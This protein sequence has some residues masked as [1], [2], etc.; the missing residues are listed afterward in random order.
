MR[1]RAFEGNLAILNGSTRLNLADVD[2]NASWDL[3]GT[4]PKGA[5][6]V[7]TRTPAPGSVE[8]LDFAEMAKDPVVGSLVGDFDNATDVRH[9]AAESLGRLADPATLET[10]RKLAEEYPEHSVRRT[11][12]R[13][14]NQVTTQTMISLHE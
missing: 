10:M 4:G 9:A 14:C 5:Q 7:R 1:W 2:G 6:L 8:P 12:L 3:V 13:A 11:L